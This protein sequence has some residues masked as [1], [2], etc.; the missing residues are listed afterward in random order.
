MAVSKAQQLAKD[1]YR[2]EKRDQINA[3]V[4]KGKRDEYKQAAARF[5]ISLAQLIQNGVEEFIQNHAG[6]DF[7]EANQ[8]TA[9]GA[10][11]V[12]KPGETLS[13][14]EKKLLEEFRQMP[15]N[16]QKHVRGLI[17]AIIGAQVESD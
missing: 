6:E 16:S 1:K 17:R 10:S 13:R 5:G 11:T 9:A 12:E 15:V 3:E 14:E 8:L 7:S 2:T 4:P